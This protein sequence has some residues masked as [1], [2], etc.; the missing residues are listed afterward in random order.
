[1]LHVM[2]PREATAEDLPLLAAAL[3]EAAAWREGVHAP[4]A[5]IIAPVSV[6]RYVK[7]WPRPGDAGVV[8][9]GVGASWW[10]LFTAEAP[11]YGF[12]AEDVGELT[13]GVLPHA[14][15]QGAGTALLLALVDNARQQGMRGLSLSVERDN[16]AVA[17]YRR[18]GFLPVQDTGG[19]LTMVLWL[20]TDH[21]PPSPA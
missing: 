20:D 17:L 6:A 4:V 19:A 12:V 16:P 11:G 1:M 10:R 13:L 9:D 15:G 2:H 8:L 7:G 14:R 18:V 21:A 3:A 5:D